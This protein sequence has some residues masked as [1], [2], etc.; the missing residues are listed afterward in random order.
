MAAYLLIFGVAS[1]LLAERLR[2]SFTAIIG[3][4]QQLLARAVTMRK[5]AE[6][7]STT[8]HS[9]A[10][11][12]RGKRRSRMSPDAAQQLKNEVTSFL[13]KNR[14]ATRKQLTDAV[15]LDTQAIYRRIMTELQ[16]EGLIMSKGEKS[17]AVYSLKGRG[18]SKT[19]A[20]K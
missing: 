20:K 5:A 6:D 8:K 1:T 13:A 10:K 11:V 4:L 19:V 16:Q 17:K 14:W 7:R 2:K 3:A 9:A 15:A 12:H 18:L